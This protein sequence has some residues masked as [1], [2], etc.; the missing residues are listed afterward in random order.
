MKVHVLYAD[1]QGES[2]WRDDW[3]A[4]EVKSFAPP[5]QGIEISAPEVATQMLF[6]R[7][8][9]GWDEPIH[10]TPLRQ[11]LICLTGAVCVTAS[12]GVQRE[13]GTG[14]VWHMED[15]HGKGHHTRVTSD[16]DFS[17]VIVQLP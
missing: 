7:L 10:P 8:P 11:K 15:M 5:A 4:L 2:H 16:V 13:I 12:D 6:L 17:A 3:P 14:E 9:V 1:A